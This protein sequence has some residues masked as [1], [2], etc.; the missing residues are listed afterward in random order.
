MSDY[1][2]SFLKKYFDAAEKAEK[3]GDDSAMDDAA[4]EGVRFY[5][6][7]LS[8]MVNENVIDL[9]FAYAA[10]RLTTEALRNNL[11]FAE[12][13]LAEL[14]IGNSAVTSFAVSG[15]TWEKIKEEEKK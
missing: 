6:N 1:E 11:S 5:V 14:L 2:S 7:E 4:S 15:D 13:M 10:M 12:K 8:D 9:V 3:T